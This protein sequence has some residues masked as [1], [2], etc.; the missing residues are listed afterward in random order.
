MN[1]L[2]QWLHRILNYRAARWSPDRSHVWAPL[3]DA[4]FDISSADR[5]TLQAK[6]R[7]WERE[8]GLYQKLCDIWEQYVSGP[9]GM[10]VVSQSSVD[11]WNQAAD[12]E[13]SEWSRFPDLTSL[14]PLS[15]L[16]GLVARSW[17]VD[18]ECFA[19][20]TVGDSG[21]PRLQLIEAHRVKTPE[22]LRDGEGI[23]IIDGVAVDG[24]GRPTGYWVTTKPGESVLVPS[25]RMIHV[26]EPNRIGQYR[27]IPIATSVLNDLHD[28][29]DLQRYEMLAAKGA[30][31][32][33]NVIKRKGGELSRAGLTRNR[34]S[35]SQTSATGS[36]ISENTVQHA[37][38]AMPGRTIGLGLDEEIQQFQST[39]P[40]VA[41][42]QYWDFLIS[43]ICAGCGISKL[44]VFPHSMQGT[45]VRAD[46]DT[47]DAFFRS[48]STVIQSF[49]QDV[50]EYV[51]T[52]SLRFRPELRSL[53]GDWTKV[54]IQPPRSVKVDIGYDSAA[55]IAEL[56]AGL[57]TR[58][59]FW[60]AR[61]KHWRDKARQLAAETAELK[62]IATEYG[63]TPGEL[64]EKL[65]AQT[66]DTEQSE[67]R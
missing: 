14:Q 1:R 26:F 38:E 53:P 48:R 34:F 45:V 56:A 29:E 13:F 12:R 4:R 57:G 15:T 9:E 58:Q 67:S 32:I 27:G 35:I 18:G 16:S 62:K 10:P 31:T 43:K 2:R 51:I 28:L 37:R 42:Q 39:R 40:S 55:T 11:A 33:T 24:N 46:L 54:A 3:Q 36:T 49:L 21:R 61:G 8:S 47:Q 20:K 19:R 50:R 65:N 41:T 30:A 52:T 5:A 23:S 59:D 63:L 7:E 22:T 64:D 17:F 44:L 66:T 25:D 6:S 60:A